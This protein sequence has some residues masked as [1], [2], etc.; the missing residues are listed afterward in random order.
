MWLSLSGIVYGPATKCVVLDLGNWNTLARDRVLV[1]NVG[2][3]ILT[4][5]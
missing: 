5:V 1:Y 3:V 2:I 4:Y